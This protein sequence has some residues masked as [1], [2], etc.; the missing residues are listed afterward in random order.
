[1]TCAAETR[2][3]IPHWIE[4]AA[5]APLLTL[6]HWYRVSQERAALRGL[7]DARLADLGLT[8]DAALREAARPFWDASPRR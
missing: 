4:I 5:I 2:R 3:S 8:R 6:V 1:M 7:S